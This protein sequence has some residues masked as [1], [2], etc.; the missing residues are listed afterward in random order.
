MD[1][2]VRVLSFFMRMYVSL[3]L[4]GRKVF[5]VTGLRRSGNHA[6]IYW[7]ANALEDTKV[8]FS[9][10]YE[11]TLRGDLSFIFKS[12]SGKIVFYNEVN[13]LGAYNFIKKIRSTREYIGKASYVIVSLEDYVP[14][15]RDV[16]VP[17]GAIK[18]AIKRRTLDLV[19]SRLRRAINQA[20]VGMD[21]GDMSIDYRF[22][23]FLKW[24]QKSDKNDWLVWSYDK[25]IDDKDY[26]SQFLE[27]LDLRSDITPNVSSFGDGS[28]FTGQSKLPGREDLLNRWH[29]V[30]WPTR[31]LELLDDIDDPSTLDNEEKSFISY[32][33]EHRESDP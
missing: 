3:A 22:T 33:L 9:H 11:P 23:D 21:R 13:R 10:I 15:S 25:W 31:V 6:F 19:A 26:R 8:L 1:R 30:T 4:R 29:Q 18:I 27:K 32:Q 17:N 14:K 7:L 5:V 20:S 2:I 16:F 24:L 28:S 12:K